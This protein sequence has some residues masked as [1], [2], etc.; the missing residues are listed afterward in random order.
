LR[1]V[2][3]DCTVVGVPGRIVY[4]AGERVDPLE[5]GRLPD[6]EAEVI[7]ALV[8]RLEAMEQQLQLLQ[9]RQSLANSYYQDATEPNYAIAVPVGCVNSADPEQCAQETPPEATQTLPSCR[10]RDKVIEQFL[11]GSGI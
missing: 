10:L 11:D 2:P 8:D 5:H 3:S 7:R 4:R 9:G 1:D 6:S